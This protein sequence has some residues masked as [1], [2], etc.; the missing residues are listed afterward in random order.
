MIMT[1][2]KKVAEQTMAFLSQWGLKH[3]F[4]AKKCKIPRSAF[5]SFIHGRLALSD[6]QLACIEEY[7]SDYTRRNS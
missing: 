4:V 3:G 7:T 2:Q 6:R 5:S 1:E